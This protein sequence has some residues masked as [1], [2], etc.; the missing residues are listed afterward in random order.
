MPLIGENDDI[1]LWVPGPS[2]AFLPA[3]APFITAQN[4]VLAQMKRIL[5]RMRSQVLYLDKFSPSTNWKVNSQKIRVV[6]EV[7]A[8]MELNLQRLNTRVPVPS[9]GNFAPITLGSINDVRL[10]PQALATLASSRSGR[11]ASAHVLSSGEVLL[12]AINSGRDIM[13][14]DFITLAGLYL[15]DDWQDSEV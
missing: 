4:S 13:P 6:G 5:R 8:Y 12:D 1:P 3:E 14:N 9:D 15:L 2:S 10:Q 7:W 11:L